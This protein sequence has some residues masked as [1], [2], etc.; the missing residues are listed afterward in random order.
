MQFHARQPQPAPLAA[1]SALE[2]A[3]LR[4]RYQADLATLAARPGVRIGAAP[5]LVLAAE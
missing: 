5:E 1:F 3:R 4:R 2:A